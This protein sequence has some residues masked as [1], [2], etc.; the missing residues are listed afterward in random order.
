M[1]TLNF[2]RKKIVSIPCSCEPIVEMLTS[3][4]CHM[5]CL[6]LHTNGIITHT[7]RESEREKKGRDRKKERKIMILKS[8]A[9]R[10]RK[11]HGEIAREAEK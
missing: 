4:F 1:E 9:R 2:S 10:D 7:A 5:L 8:R 6:L 3:Q 11:R